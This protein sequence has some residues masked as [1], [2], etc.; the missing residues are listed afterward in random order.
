MTETE[1]IN[2]SN[3][4]IRL[5]I[6]KEGGFQINKTIQKKVKILRTIHS[7]EADEIISY[8][9]YNYIERE[10]YKKFNPQ[11]G[12]L[13]TFLI[14]YVNNALRNMLRVFGNKKKKVH[15]VEL[16]DGYKDI[17]EYSSRK[18]LS[19][20]EQRDFSD[21]LHNIK[22]PEYC[23]LLKEQSQILENFFGPADSEVLLTY[24]TRKE[25][26]TRRGLSY[27]AYRK[28]LNRKYHNFQLYL[29][30]TYL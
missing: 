1:I 5:L 12:K 17:Y 20:L 6:I 24:R 19:Y 25:E 13:S 4:I 16:P 14:H 2:R 3:K 23:L 26:A 27:E 15:E 18:S 8:I 11:K 28:K 30:A 29:E 22:T 7:L 10:H 9:F 21:Q